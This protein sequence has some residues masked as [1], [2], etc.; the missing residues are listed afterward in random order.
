MTPLD[1]VANR[2]VSNDG[3]KIAFQKPSVL[4]SAYSRD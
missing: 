3:A 4:F 1:V 2:K